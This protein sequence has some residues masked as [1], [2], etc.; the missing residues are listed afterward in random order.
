MLLLRHRRRRERITKLREIPGNTPASSP[1]DP[2]AA[3]ATATV[4]NVMC[5]DFAEFAFFF[6][7]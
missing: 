2:S 5:I 6:F 1:V 4:Q 7:P 3:A